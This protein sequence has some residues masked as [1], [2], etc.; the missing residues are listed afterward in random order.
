MQL[1]AVS[2]TALTIEEAKGFSIVLKLI[3]LEK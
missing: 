1:H 2:N 3:M